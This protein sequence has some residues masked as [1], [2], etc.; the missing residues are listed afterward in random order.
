MMRIFGRMRTKSRHVA[1]AGGVL[2]EH[3]VET[4]LGIDE[5]SFIAGHAIGKETFHAA[6]TAALRVTAPE[7][8]RFAVAVRRTENGDGVCLVK[9]RRKVS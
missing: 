4:A 1:E 2:A 3:V 8:I 6:P 7:E 9:I 5:V